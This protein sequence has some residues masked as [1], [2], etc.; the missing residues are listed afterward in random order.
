MFPRKAEGRGYDRVVSEQL[1]IEDR[2]PEKRPLQIAEFAPIDNVG[3]KVEAAA[4]DNAL[5]I[6]DREFRVPPIVE[7]HGEW[8]E[9]Q[10]AS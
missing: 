5:N 6:L 8:S 10:I 1:D 9:I 7:M 4:F 2:G 3:V